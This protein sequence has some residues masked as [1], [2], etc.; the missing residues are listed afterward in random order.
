MDIFMLVML[1]VY[2][3]IAL[4]RIA[5]LTVEDI[6]D[7]TDV[8]REEREVY[9]SIPNTEYYTRAVMVCFVSWLMYTFFYDGLLW[10]IA[11]LKGEA[12]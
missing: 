2:A 9:R 8:V 4:Y 12:R 5:L 7:F 10:P 1:A 6:V 11:I 3:G